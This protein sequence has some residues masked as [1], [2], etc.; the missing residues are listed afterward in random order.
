MV[1]FGG[2]PFFDLF[3]PYP[4]SGNSYVIR[5][6]SLNAYRGYTM[7]TPPPIYPAPVFV[8]EKKGK[9]VVIRPPEVGSA[10]DFAVIGY[11]ITLLLSVPWILISLVIGG[12]GVAAFLG[13]IVLPPVLP[14]ILIGIPYLGA[15][16]AFVVFV[17]T[18][19]YLVYLGLGGFGLLVAIILLGSIYF[20]IVRGIS[21]GKYEKARG[22]SLFWAVLFIIPSFAVLFSSLMSGAIIALIPAFFFMLTY[23]RLGE[24]VAKYGP[25]AVMGEAVP[26]M[27]SVAPAMPPGPMPMGGPVPM[28]GPMPMGGHM[29]MAPKNPQC[30]TCSR[31][32]YYSAI[33]R[34]WYCQ[35]CDNP[36]GHR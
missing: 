22:A 1:I 23:G 7:E 34:R 29:P 8:E 27:P 12:V 33:H 3:S 31:D 35:N 19:S 20:G 4:V 16:L 32:L 36:T 11:I 17:L 9:P 18:S 28:G 5:R 10:H 26:G 30:P 2:R 14:P 25:V 15:I 13:L 21:K 24:V 6:M